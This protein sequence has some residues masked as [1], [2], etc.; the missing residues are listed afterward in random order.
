MDVAKKCAHTANFPPLFLENKTEKKRKKKKWH[1]IETL[2]FIF[3]FIPLSTIIM[4]Q[5]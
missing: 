5:P 2:I 1:I 4:Q 3:K